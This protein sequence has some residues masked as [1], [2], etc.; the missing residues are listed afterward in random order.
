MAWTRAVLAGALASL[1][2][3]AP[4][5]AAPDAARIGDRILDP[6]A[7]GV[8]SFENTA[9]V[10]SFQ[11]DGLFTYE[12]WQYTGFYRAD[13]TAVI[14][15]RKLP[16]GRWQSIELDYKLFADD[17]HN[18]VAMAVTPSDGRIHLAYPTHNNAIRYTRSVPGIADHPETADWSSKSFERVRSSVPG[19]P[20]APPSFTYPQF[21][22]DH[23]RM[24]LTYRD[25]STDNGR[26]VLLRYD[27]D[28][29]ATWTFLGRFTDSTGPYTS[30]YGTSNSRYAYLHGFNV[31]P[32]T[33]DLEI[34]FSWREQTS[35]WCS[36]SGLG[37]HDLGYARSPDGGMT[38]LNND[39]VPIASTSTAADND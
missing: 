5:A 6:A 22:M 26:Q 35:A 13:R 15:R 39:G 27:D 24:L 11:Q 17:S 14:S 2:L 28:A 9:N 16:A 4:A 18:T 29:D 34:S 38:W 33:G 21:E 37:N 31:N 19:A 8:V 7:R 10:S 36:P 20:A 25:G 1:A 32:V 30:P 23:G 3:T 12:G